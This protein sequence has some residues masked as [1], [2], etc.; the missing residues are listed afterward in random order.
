MIDFIKLH[1]VNSIRIECMK[2][3]TK[4]NYQGFIW[5]DDEVTNATDGKSTINRINERDAFESD[6]IL[7]ISYYLLK[8]KAL[9]SINNSLKNNNFYILRRE[10]NSL[11]KVKI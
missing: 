3:C 8:P 5:L 9:I 1:L 6:K 7:P 10:N 11:I 2:I 4:Y